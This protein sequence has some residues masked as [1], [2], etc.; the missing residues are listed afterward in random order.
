M[1]IERLIQRTAV[2]VFLC[3]LAMPALAQTRNTPCDPA[4]PNNSM[5]LT[6]DAVTESTDNRPITNVYYRVQRRIGT[7]GAWTDIAPNL[8]ATRYYDQNLSPGTYFYRVFAGCALCAAES[9]S[10][11]IASRDATAPT[12]PKAPVITIAVVVGMDHSP[13]YRLTQAGVR[14]ARY[15]DACG[16]IP[17]G[18]E[19]SGPVVYRFRDKSFR[20]VALADV[21]EWGVTCGDFAVAPCG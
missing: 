14:D 16:Y 19:C 18:K 5:C 3:V 13:V 20:R 10:S 15:A 1:N 4:T 17:V 21:K 7:T 8:T 2:I 12:I 6:W 11:N 9:A